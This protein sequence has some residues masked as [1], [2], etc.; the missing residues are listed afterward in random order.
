MDTSTSHVGFRC[1]VRQCEIEETT[2]AS[3]EAIKP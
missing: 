3:K 2:N 1:V